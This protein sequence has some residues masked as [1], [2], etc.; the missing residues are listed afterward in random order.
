MRHYLVGLHRWPDFL[1]EARDNYRGELSN[2][3]KHLGRIIFPSS[4]TVS[5]THQLTLSQ[6]DE[7]TDAQL[8]LRPHAHQLRDLQRRHSGDYSKFIVSDSRL[9]SSVEEFVAAAVLFSNATK[10]Q[11][12]KEGT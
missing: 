5:P 12:T 10:D 1:R 11:E 6:G 9:K 3:R 8:N 7:Q 2:S 4:F